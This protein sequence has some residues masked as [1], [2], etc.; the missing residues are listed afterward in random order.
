MVYIKSYQGLRAILFNC[1]LS[2]SDLSYSIFK[3]DGMKRLFLFLILIVSI[4]CLYAV[5][6]NVNDY[7]DSE[8]IEI[9]KIINLKL[10]DFQKGDIIY[11]DDN[12]SINYLGWKKEYSEN[13]LWV[14]VI[15]K[16]DKNIIVFS[17]NTSINECSIDCSSPIS[18]LAGKRIN[19]NII[20]VYDST[21][22]EQWI[23]LIDYVEFSI[24][25]YDDDD[26]FSDFSFESEDMIKIE[27]SI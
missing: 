23:D 12:I 10:V 9:R 11:E 5:N 24:K 7:T 13:S 17:D 25:Y 20:S 16:S 18:V 26:W 27:Y 14:T 19:D 22:E 15:N 1:N 8:L 6:F 4:G 3:E 2:Y 21:L